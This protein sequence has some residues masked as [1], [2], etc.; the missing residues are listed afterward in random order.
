MISV[1]LK[2]SAKTRSSDWSIEAELQM[3]TDI[4]LL[5]M[6][7]FVTSSDSLL[8]QTIKCGFLDAE[9]YS[10][11]NVVLRHV[12]TIYFVSRSKLP[13]NCKD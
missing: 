7:R 11:Q 13:S 12:S 3:S 6:R 10:K 9:Y 4:C 5:Y 8:I 2:F 1:K